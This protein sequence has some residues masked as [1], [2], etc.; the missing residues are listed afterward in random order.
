METYGFTKQKIARDRL[1][2]VRRAVIVI[3]STAAFAAL[4]F[5]WADSSSVFGAF[6]TS[7]L[8]AVG[9]LIA[10]VATE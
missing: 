7:F 8:G 6:R 10:M 9:A 2:S 1:A 3:A 5:L 4:G